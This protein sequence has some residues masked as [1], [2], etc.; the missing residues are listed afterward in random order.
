MFALWLALNDQS[1]A[2]DGNCSA[3][4][5]VALD[6]KVWMKI[7]ADEKVLVRSKASRQR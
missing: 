4:L 3:G 2:D 7:F 1:D 5:V 6:H